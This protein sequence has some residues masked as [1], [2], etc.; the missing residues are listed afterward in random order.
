MYAYNREQFFDTDLIVEQDV[1]APG[2]E[3]VTARVKYKSCN[4]VDWI[5]IFE[6]SDDIPQINLGKEQSEQDNC[7]EYCKY[8]CQKLRVHVFPN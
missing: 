4:K 5:D 3:D 8:F 1:K 2:T 7:Y 6:G